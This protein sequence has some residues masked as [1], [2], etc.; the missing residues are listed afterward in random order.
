[1][2]LREQGRYCNNCAKTVV[3][4]SMMSDEAVL[5]YFIA[6]FNEKIC[7]RFKTTQLQR[8]VIELPQNIFHIQLPFWKRFLVAFLICFGGSFFAVDTTIAG[9]NYRQGHPMTSHENA[10]KIKNDSK[11]FPSLKKKKRKKCKVYLRTFKFR[12]EDIS[13][14]TMGFTVTYPDPHDI[15]DTWTSILNP[16]EEVNSNTEKKATT[17]TVIENNTGSGNR[18][19]DSFPKYPD[20]NTAFISPTIIAA[21]NPFSKK[22][23]A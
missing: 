12:P 22:K 5:Q 2:S 4:F 6:N 21:R 14:T 20:P 16:G 7:G 17:G 9:I 3:D 10:G 23:K 8:I 1:M 15:N 19:K 13:T 18:K 11:K